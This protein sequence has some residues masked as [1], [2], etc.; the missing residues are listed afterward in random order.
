M[1]PE[2]VHSPAHPET[3][4]I[5]VLKLGQRLHSLQPMQAGGKRVILG[6]DFLTGVYL[7]AIAWR[8]PPIAADGHRKRRS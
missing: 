2:R 8:R 5:C 1:L 7:F 4:M 6:L 3:K